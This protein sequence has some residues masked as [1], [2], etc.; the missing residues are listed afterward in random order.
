MPEE[1]VCGPDPEHHLDA[2]RKYVEAGFDYVWIHRVGPDQD[3]F[4]RF[5]EHE[6]LPTVRELAPAAGR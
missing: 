6:V 2:I 5:Y 1:I 3:G 4:F